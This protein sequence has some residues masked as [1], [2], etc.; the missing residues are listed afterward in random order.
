LLAS[1]SAALDKWSTT[2]NEQPLVG[3]ARLLLAFVSAALDKWSTTG[4]EQPLVG[5]QGYCLLL[6]LLL[7]QMVNH[8]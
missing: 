2:G 1:V 7:R 8:W 6:S 5:E 3:G 4:N